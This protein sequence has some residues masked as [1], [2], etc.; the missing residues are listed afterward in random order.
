MVFL[1]VIPP[2]VNCVKSSVF[3]LAR[4]RA[5]YSLLASVNRT[6]HTCTLRLYFEI[7]S[8]HVFANG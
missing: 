4:H 6:M 8:V 2:E 1:N 7:E 3:F 5:Y